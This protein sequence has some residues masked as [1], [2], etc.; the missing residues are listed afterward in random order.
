MKKV[1]CVVLLIPCLLCILTGC[2]CKH[3][4]IEADCVTPRICSSC[5][6]TEGDVLGH[7]WIAE[8]CLSDAEYSRCSE[9]GESATGHVWRDATC[10][11]PEVCAVCGAS[12][13]NGTVPHQWFDA[14]ATAPRICSVCGAED[15]LSLDEEREA[16]KETLLKEAQELAENKEY[17][18]AMQ[19]LDNAW[20]QTREQVFYDAATGYRLRWASIMGRGSRQ[21]STTLRSLTTM[22]Q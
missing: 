1:P 14:T 10:T 12:G 8:D 16:V 17:V 4:W 5:G 6:E 21:A 3:E 18:S 9:K 20:L 7:D 22:R 11:S 13:G 19:T 2:S 15:G